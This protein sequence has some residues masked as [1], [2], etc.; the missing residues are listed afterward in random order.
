VSHASQ[1]DLHDLLAL[2]GERSGVPGLLVVPLARRGDPPAR[3]AAD[4]LA[5]FERSRLDALDLDG[6]LYLR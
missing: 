6:Q 1:P 5:V 2:F 3:S 4:A